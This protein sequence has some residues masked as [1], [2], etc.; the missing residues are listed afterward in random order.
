MSATA[1][2]VQRIEP[3][4]AMHTLNPC[5]LVRFAC[6]SCLLKTMA[7]CVTGLEVGSFS[8]LL[9]LSYDQECSNNYNEENKPFMVTMCKKYCLRGEDSNWSVSLLVTEEGDNTSAF[10]GAQ[11]G[12]PESSS[13][14]HKLQTRRPYV[15]GGGLYYNRSWSP[16]DIS[17]VLWSQRNSGF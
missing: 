16:F 15:W 13:V 9:F 4:L 5:L 10:C 11:S 14:C 1:F 12:G 6:I 3:F 2:N 8:L 17:S 7:Q